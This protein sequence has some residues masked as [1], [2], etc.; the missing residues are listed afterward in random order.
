[1]FTR[2]K[3]LGGA[4]G[5][6]IAS[7]V[8]ITT[9]AQPS[10]GPLHL[11]I[12]GPP[13][14]GADA[15]AR[16]ITERLPGKVGMPAIVDYK[17]GAAGL[18]A[19]KYVMSQ[20][21]NGL[22]LYLSSSL[23]VNAPAI[24]PETQKFNP[25][26]DLTPV[27]RLTQNLSVFLVRADLPVRTLD[28][29]INH[30]R[31]NPGKVSIGTVGQGSNSHLASAYLAKQAKLDVNIVHYKGSAPAN[32]DLMGGVIDAKFDNLASTRSTIDSGRARLIALGSRQ[33]SSLY[34]DFKLF[35]DSVPGLFFEDHFVVVAPPKMA[36]DLTDRLSRYLGEIVSS[37]DV[38][39]K[40]RD[41]LGAIAAPLG[42]KETAAYLSSAFETTKRQARFAD[43][44]V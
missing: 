7:A 3:L 43:L 29:F 28:E 17:P 5:S 4:L 25:V 13:G 30:C 6:T 33:Q 21:P 44:K 23:Y 40:L 10:G 18:I 8:P 41:Q 19:T 39:D 16:I 32:Q 15:I 26:T 22:T 42:P 12:P 37:R 1:M 31:A 24:D 38:A 34:P 36:P 2:R 9:N 11:V 27:A 35:Q 14:G 20:P